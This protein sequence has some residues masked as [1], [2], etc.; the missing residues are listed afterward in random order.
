MESTNTNM[1]HPVVTCFGEV[2]WDVLPEGPQPGGAPLNVAYHLKKLGISSG[3]ISK[4]GN[5]TLGTRLRNLIDGW[6]I[7]TNFLQLDHEYPTSEVI[8]TVTDN[9]VSY[10]I[11]QPVAW[12]FIEPI[13]SGAISHSKYL[14]YGSLASRSKA[15]RETL[16]A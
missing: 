12:D 16:P 8:A 13:N 15:S 14:V 11:V 1:I 3:I 10:E 7:D 5:D 6:D 2:L 4:T 9:E